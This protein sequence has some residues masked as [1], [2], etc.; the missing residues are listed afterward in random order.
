M[1]KTAVITLSFICH[2]HRRD[3]PVSGPEV[4]GPLAVGQQRLPDL[5]RIEVRPEEG[6]EVVLA[7]CRLPQEEITEPHLSGSA[8]YQVGVRE[9]GRIQILAEQLFVDGIRRP[10]SGPYSMPVTGPELGSGLHELSISTVGGSIVV[11]EVS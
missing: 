11:S 8:N 5:F 9:P 1:P 10:E 3:G 6:R 7:I 4:A 2:Q